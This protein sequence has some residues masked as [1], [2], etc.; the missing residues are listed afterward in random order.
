MKDNT[1]KRPSTPGFTL[2]ELLVVIAIIA[3]LAAMLLPALANAKERAKRITCINH[4][5]QLGASLAMYS[6]D[7]NDKV[8]PSRFTDTATD[9][10]DA[11]YDAYYSALPG[12]AGFSPDTCTFGLATIYD[13]K[14]AP[15]GQVFYCLS[16]TQLKAGTAESLLDRKN[17]RALFQRPPW[18]SLLADL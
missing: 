6:S 4:L 9:A 7:Y 12:D 14:T 15:N 17:L 16:G 8:P 2:I 1:L 11:C 5:H 13:Q 18:L 3:I 10:T